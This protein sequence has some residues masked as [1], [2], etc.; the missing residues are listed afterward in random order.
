MMIMTDVVTP[1]VIAFTGPTSK[2]FGIFVKLFAPLYFDNRF[3][4]DYRKKQ[5]E[6]Y[7]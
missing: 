3:Q 4:F 1:L 5:F 7:I 6:C 2:V